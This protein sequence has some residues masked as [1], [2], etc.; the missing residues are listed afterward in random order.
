MDPQYD[1]FVSYSRLDELEVLP[2][3]ERL[4]QEG[5]SV[6]IDRTGIESGDAFKQVIFDAIENSGVFLF[7]SSKNSNASTWTAKEIGVAV[8]LHKT[9]IP[10]K[11]DDSIPAKEVQF[12]II[13]LNYC[14]FTDPN[15]KEEEFQKLVAAL[16]NKSRLFNSQSG[17]QI[18]ESNNRKRI[19]YRSLLYVL[20]LLLAFGGILQIIV[21]TSYK[22]E[23]PI[24]AQRGRILDEYGRVLAYSDVRFDV[25]LNGD[26]IPSRKRENCYRDIAGTLSELIGDRNAYQYYSQLSNPHPDSSSCI[27]IVK[28]ISDSTRIMLENAFSSQRD[29]S[30]HLMFLPKSTRRYPYGDLAKAYIGRLM[31]EQ[32]SLAGNL[33]SAFQEVLAGKNGSYKVRKLFPRTKAALE[34][35][36]IRTTLNVDFQQFGDE[37]LRECMLQDAKL[38]EGTLV[39]MEVNSGAVKAVVNLTMDSETGCIKEQ[40]NHVLTKLYEPGASFETVTLLSALKDGYIHSIQDSIPTNHGSI[41][42]MSIDTHILDYERI[43]GRKM[44]SIEHGFNTS[45]SYVFAYLGNL[46]RDD[47]KRYFNNIDDFGFNTNLCPELHI[48]SPQI[49]FPDT[50]D[51]TRLLRTAYG[52][53]VYVTPIHMITFYNAIANHGKMVSPLLVYDYEKNGKTVDSFSR[54]PINEICT[55]DVAESV[56]NALHE[57]TVSGT[58]NRL[59]NHNFA[60]KTGTT[61][62]VINPAS[63]D[64]YHDDIGRF[65]SLGSF[66]G[67]FP[68]ENPKYTIFVYLCS[69]PSGHSIYG[70]TLPVIVARDL[71]TAFY[72]WNPSLKGDAKWDRNYVR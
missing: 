14:D 65:T 3:V 58:A 54:K 16:R 43:L 41:Q 57:T 49:A 1:I 8:S 44:I 53:C 13:N 19:V 29:I 42:G 23:I 9:I 24:P 67:F 37:I 72:E 62:L 22:T 26:A 6:W 15:L 30:K 7:F 10:I 68:T 64:P 38:A 69:K 11:L 56:I 45:S 60:G 4:K 52:Y 5:F 25:F 34:G 55:E 50:P 47:P 61:R 35:R 71:V 12:D 33:E 39:I 51:S 70:G 20:C 63:K 32:D 59:K 21:S 17:K 36:D 27:L 66:I 48:A 28:N 2:C 40:A 46:Y 18:K 31:Q